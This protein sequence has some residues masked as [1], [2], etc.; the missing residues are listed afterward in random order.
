MQ[1]FR[2]TVG[3]GGE[4][5]YY[6]QISEDELNDLANEM[7]TLTYGQ[8][9]QAA[10][11]R[12]VPAHVAF[13]KK[14]LKF[15]G[16]FKETVNESQQEY[17]RVRPIEVY[18]YLEDDSIAII[19]P[20][21]ENSGIPQGKFLKRQQLPK[22]DQ[23]NNWHWKDINIGDDLVVYGKVFRLTNCDLFT[24]EFLASEGIVLNSPE[25]IPVDPY[26][27]G[28][29]FTPQT[30]IT[31]SNWDKRKKFLELDRKV[32]RFYAVW[33]DREQ[34]FGEM[35]PF[36]MHYFLVDDTLEIREVHAANDGHDPFPVLVKRQKV[37]KDRLDVKS[38]Y[39]AI[40]LELSEDETK[41]WFTPGDF[42]IGLTVF[43][44]GRRFL[45]YNVDGF[46][47][48]YYRDLYR[49]NDFKPIDV[50]GPAA[51]V[52]DRIIPPYNGFGSLED[53]EQNCKSFMPKPP[54]KDFIKM[55]EYD[56]DT[57][58]YEL[59]LVSTR[60]EDAQRRFIMSY[61]LADDHLSIYERNL[62]NSGI[63]GGSYLSASRIP[64]PGQ[65]QTDNPLYYTPSHF[66]IGADLKI[67]KHHFKIVNADLHVLT[68]LEQAAEF[69][70]KA[71]LDSLRAI[72]RK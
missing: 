72:H 7:P 59:K 60:P 22:D 35:R 23:G 31:K 71:V 15:V 27:E 41:D 5:L 38:S 61:R 36:I 10:P 25:A 68:V 20:K 37:P 69:Y 46:T 9:K 51:H 16:Y 14:V 30:C 21:V 8:S 49:V 67:L 26:T 62:R 58:R 52:P 42:K 12:F 40:V 64:V 4:R 18:Y 47:Q 11:E 44:Y 28:R 70:P 50:K 48:R 54:K 45:I 17:Y 63:M 65:G 39:P 66:A 6:N 1:Q 56:M 29:I 3:Y 13:D 2:P 32:L 19:E 34:M 53:S 24:Q 43:I 55:L 33:D 57:L